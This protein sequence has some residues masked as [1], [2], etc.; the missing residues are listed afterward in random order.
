MAP[1]L[2]VVLAV[3]AFVTVAVVILDL[4]QESDPLVSGPSPFFAA[5]LG[6]PWLGWMMARCALFAW[7]LRMLGSE[8]G[9]AGGTG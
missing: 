4:V 6:V 8:E 9:R 5:C 3:E 1:M 7:C 2:K